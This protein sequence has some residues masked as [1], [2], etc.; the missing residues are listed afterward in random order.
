MSTAGLPG[1]RLAHRTHPIAGTTDAEAGAAT[2]AT[3]PSDAAIMVNRARILRSLTVSS[4][5]RISA[6]QDTRVTQPEARPGRQNG[7]SRSPRRPLPA[8]TVPVTV[9]I[10]NSRAYAASPVQPERVV[11][12]DVLW[13]GRRPAR[14]AALSCSA[15]RTPPRC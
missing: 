10:W 3:Q 13:S 11:E 4:S 1:E 9:V 12:S 14:P 7:G 8:H 5:R 2:K 15:G 6:L